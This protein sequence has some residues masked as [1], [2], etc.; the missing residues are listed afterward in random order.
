MS[1]G[2][3]PRWNYISRLTSPPA[4]GC[5]GMLGNGWAGAAHPAASF[6]HDFAA[7]FAFCREFVT[8]CQEFVIKLQLYF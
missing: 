5:L 3:T 7:S 1:R 2:F 4:L 8:L 6:S